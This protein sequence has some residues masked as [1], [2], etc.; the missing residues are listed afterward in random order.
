MKL[1]KIN[2]PAIHDKDLENI[3]NDYNLLEDFK[4]SNLCCFNCNDIIDIDNLTGV[5]VENET[6]LF[7]CD[8]PDC[9]AHATSKNDKNI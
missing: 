2:L 5:I 1:K 7:V 9:L 4:S 6:L 3:L 8:S